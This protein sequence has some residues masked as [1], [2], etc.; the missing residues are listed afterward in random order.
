MPRIRNDHDANNFKE[1]IKNGAV[2][3][4]AG[5]VGMPYFSTDTW[6][7]LRWL[8]INSKKV[9]VSENGT[10]EMYDKDPNTINDPKINRSTTYDEIFSTKLQDP[11]LTFITMWKEIDIEKIFFDIKKKEII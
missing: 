2:V 8:E 4:F 10:D 7:A 11:D 9:L 6:A 5:V 1:D 3:I